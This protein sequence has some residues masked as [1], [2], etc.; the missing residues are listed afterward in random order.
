MA[1][2][3]RPRRGFDVDEFIR[4]VAGRAELDLATAERVARAVFL[5]LAQAL[6][7]DE[8][9]DVQ[10]QL[11]K[12]F[13]SLL[14]RGPAVEVL[15]LEELLDRVADRAGRDLD[16][17]RRATEA[18]LDRVAEREGVTREQAFT[19]ARAVFTPSTRR[20]GTR[21]SSTPPSSC[22]PTTRSS[23]RPRQRHG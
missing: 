11:L 14:P 21:S 17:A 18:A 5:A 8:F 19:D 2:H 9:A 4:R 3:H 20:S 10:A 6:S 7:A 12:D 15:P 16:G 22:H 13:A 1:V 23:G